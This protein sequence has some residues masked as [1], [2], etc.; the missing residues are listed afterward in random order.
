MPCARL[1][2]DKFEAN[3]SSFLR[4]GSRRREAVVR[5]KSVGGAFEEEV[6]FGVW[7]CKL[8]HR[9]DALNVIARAHKLPSLII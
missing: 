2:S 8:K 9:K 5:W 7:E 3:M 1:R 4:W 6:F